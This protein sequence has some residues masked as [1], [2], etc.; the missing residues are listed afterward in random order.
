MRR[1][2]IAFVL[3][4]GALALSTGAVV[5]ADGPCCYSLSQVQQT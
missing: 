4:F 3:A 5:A 2:I 1:F